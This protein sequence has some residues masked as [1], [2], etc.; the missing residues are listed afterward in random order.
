MGVDGT[1]QRFTSSFDGTSTLNGTLKN[2]I[3]EITTGD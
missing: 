3:Y 2:V 1:R